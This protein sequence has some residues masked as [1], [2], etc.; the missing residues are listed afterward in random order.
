MSTRSIDCELFIDADPEQ[1]FL[2]FTEAEQLMRWFAPHVRS[3]PGLGG[4]VNL[5]WDADGSSKD[6]E[7]VEWQPGQRLVLNWYAGPDGETCLPVAVDFVAADGGTLLRLVHS[8]FLSD[9]SWDDEFDSHSRGWRY[10]LRSLKH[11]LERH[12]GFARQHL[13]ERIAISGDPVSAWSAL[14]GAKGAFHFTGEFPGKTGSKSQA[15]AGQLRLPDGQVTGAELLLE[16]T[17]TDFVVVADVLEGGVLRFALETFSSQPEIWMWAFSWRLAEKE[18]LNRTLPWF[19]EVRSR[20]SSE[21]LED[22]QNLG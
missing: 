1:V 16:C 2:A 13:L 6:C 11:Y 14:V 12:F 17:S 18:L 3:E 22:H 20:L 21:V 4:F 15:N 7:I 10:E 9:E 19:E 8:G 5:L